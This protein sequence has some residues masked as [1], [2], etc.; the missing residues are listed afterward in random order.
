MII[1]SLWDCFDESETG[2]QLLIVIQAFLVDLFLA[3]IKFNFGTGGAGVEEAEEEGGGEKRIG[4]KMI[5]SLFPFE[6]GAL[7]LHSV[8]RC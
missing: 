3:L 2:S 5:F 7:D 8:F 4:G 6:S 1:G